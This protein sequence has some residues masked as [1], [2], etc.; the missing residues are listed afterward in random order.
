MV[1]LWDNCADLLLA[2]KL[3]DALSEHHHVVSHW[4]GSCKQKVPIEELTGLVRVVNDEVSELL[5]THDDSEALP[6]L[7]KLIQARLFI[8]V[9]A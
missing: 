6:P 5:V 9:K 1:A 4:V 8:V 2:P 7:L 3:Q